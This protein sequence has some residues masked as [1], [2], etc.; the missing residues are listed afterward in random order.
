MKL[1][2]SRP[3]RI[4]QTKIDSLFAKRYFVIHWLVKVPA[5]FESFC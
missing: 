1:G 2:N 3:K 5:A 4:N